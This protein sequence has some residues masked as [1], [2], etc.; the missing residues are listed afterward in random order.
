VV[1]AKSCASTAPEFTNLEARG[2]GGSMTKRLVFHVLFTVVVLAA[3]AAS[4]RPAVGAPSHP[5]DG[6][7]VGAAVSTAGPAPLGGWSPVD[8][9][10]PFS[11]DYSGCAVFVAPVVNAAYEQT[12]VELVNRER[13]HFSNLPPLK[14]TAALDDAARYHSTDLGQD[15]YFSH[16]SH[17][18]D[19]GGNLVWAC[20]WATRVQNFYGAYNALAENVAAGYTTPA[21]VMLG[22]M[23]SSGHKNNIMNTSVRALGVGYACCSGTYGRYWTQDFGRKAAVYPLVINREGGTT[24]ST[25]V[26]L[27]L[28][29]AWAEMRLRNDSDPWGA[30]Q[31]FNNNL[32]WTL[33]GALGTHT[34]HAEMRS[35]GTTTS[36]SDSI[37]LVSGSPTA[38]PTSVS[39]GAPPPTATGAAT[40]TA[41]RTNTPISPTT[42]PTNTATAT[43][44]STA[45]PPT[46]TLLPSATLAATSTATRT[47]TPIPPTTVPTNT[48]TATRTST[49]V[50]PSATPLP[51]AT[52]AAT[53]TATRTATPIPPTTVPTNTATATRTSTAVPPSATPLPSATLAAT[54]TATRTNTAVPPTATLAATST[55]VAFT[56]VHDGFTDNVFPTQNFGALTYLFTRGGG[57]S[58]RLGYFKFVV[59]GLTRSVQSATLRLFVADGTAGGGYV[60]RSSNDFS[61]GGAWTEGALNWGNQPT[62]SGAPLSSFGTLPAGP[63]RD[64]D[65]TSAVTG[66]G[67]VSLLVRTLT[68][69]QAEFGSHEATVAEERPS[70]II[71]QAP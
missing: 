13:L 8:I 42:V 16:D 6:G 39:T 18:R 70:L 59:T 41:T 25:S 22:W 35:G 46:A 55:P 33:P 62:V 69:D 38:T 49:T 17:D 3:A 37:I 36:A 27:Y 20:G 54:S 64:F 45:V 57:S 21:A 71:V 19:G 48:L 12:V 47:A 14:R 4:A 53:S 65:V 26:S 1:D 5:A 63:G 29:G 9:F 56:S 2:I 44:T 30:W 15:N 58:M 50:P 34:V 23:N 40:A 7:T 32:A 67:T 66:N 28:Y 61:T 24:T 68:A 43:R 10:S 52:L 11:L 31:T 60:Y 51:S